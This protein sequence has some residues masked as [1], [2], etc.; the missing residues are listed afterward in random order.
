MELGEFTDTLAHLTAGEIHEI[1][2]AICHR[3]AT[4]A[5]DVDWWEATIAIERSLKITHRTRAAAMAA[6]SA[7][8][9]VQ[10]AAL[11][12]GFALPDGEVTAVARAAGEIA[13]GLAAG[14]PGL[15]AVQ[16]LL[17]GWRPLAASAA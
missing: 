17:S 12:E 1:A 3:H 2:A 5:G 13:R 7:S 15:D 9:A 6:L 4:P 16:V 8:R 10:H 14:A 11:A